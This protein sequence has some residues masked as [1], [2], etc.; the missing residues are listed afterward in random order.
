MRSLGRRPTPAL[1]VAA[2]VTAAVVV[3]VSDTGPGIPAEDLP[4]VFERFWQK[5]DGDRRGVGLGLGIAKAIVE[6]HGGRIHVESTPGH[7]STFAF[8]LPIALSKPTPSS[9][10][11]RDP[12]SAPPRVGDASPTPVSTPNGAQRSPRHA[13]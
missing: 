10:E 2:E 1:R 11:G 3:E 7:G 13:G 8:T 5:R 9:G 12:D 6:A 4:Y